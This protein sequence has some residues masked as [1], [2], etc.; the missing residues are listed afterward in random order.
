M[1]KNKTIIIAEAGVNHNGRL[2]TAKRLINKASIAGADIIKFQTFSTDKLVL[3]NKQKGVG[4][5]LYSMLRR[6][7]LSFEEFKDISKICK[8]RKIEFLSTGFDIDSL[9]LLQF[10]KLK[11]LKIPSGEITNYPLLKF[12][13]KLKKKIIL[14]TGMST[15]KEIESAL[16]VLNKYGTPLKKITVLHC[17][18][19]YPTPI[20]DANLKAM[21]TIKN[22]FGVEVGYSDHTLGIEAPIIAVSLGAK[23]IEKHFTLNR[24]YK[25][26]DHKTS[27]E[28]NELREMVLAIRKTEKYLGSGEKNV[29]KSE[30]ENKNLV[31]KSIA[32]LKNIKKGE[33]FSESNLT[34]KRPGYGISAMKWDEIIGKKAKRNYK[35]NEFI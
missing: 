2:D 8:K 32:T 13:A 7:E 22:R 29:T 23:I 17:N 5:S 16:K 25:G 12:A 35:I 21:V 28:P 20:N 11:R 18:S 4:K 9:K 3:F 14:S 15:I 10:F 1:K 33:K 26:P 19:S 6:L 24:N 31:R 34:T 27:I 30:K